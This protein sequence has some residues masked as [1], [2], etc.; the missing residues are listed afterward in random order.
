MAEAVAKGVAK[1]KVG[2][3]FT[4]PVFSTHRLYMSAHDTT[5]RLLG[6]K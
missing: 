1:M 6:F 3:R 4:C 2:V 5:I